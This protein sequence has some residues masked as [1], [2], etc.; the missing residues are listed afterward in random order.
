MAPRMDLRH[1]SSARLGSTGNTPFFIAWASRDLT[2]GHRQDEARVWNASPACS[3][4]EDGDRMLLWHG[5]R[6]TNFAG[7]LKQGL[8]IAPPEGE[9]P[10]SRCGITIAD[11]DI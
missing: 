11:I 10:H 9:D 3:E 1:R 6:S 5:S 2:R 4:L 7:I 8:R